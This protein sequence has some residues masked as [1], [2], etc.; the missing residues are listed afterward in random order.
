MKD[1]YNN[2]KITS[3]VGYK[4]GSCH[5]NTKFLEYQKD[6]MFVR[7]LMSNRE[8]T[9]EKMIKHAVIS[10][11]AWGVLMLVIW[12]IFLNQEIIK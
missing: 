10:V 1:C 2:P 11:L 7:N 9:A 3:R 4:I 5:S 12:F 6:M 8:R